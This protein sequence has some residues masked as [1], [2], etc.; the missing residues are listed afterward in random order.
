M[1]RDVC[2]YSVLVLD[3]PITT[4]DKDWKV[5]VVRIVLR[6]VAS[7]LNRLVIDVPQRTYSCRL[8]RS[9]RRPE[10][11]SHAS[12]WNVLAVKSVHLLES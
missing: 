3:L 7:L 5:N 12:S 4:H 1:Q 10:R 2:V 9:M 11:P 8:L 6:T